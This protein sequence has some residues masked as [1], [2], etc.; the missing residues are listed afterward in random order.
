MVPH[1]N[2]ESHQ[3]S[4]SLTTMSTKGFFKQEL[5]IFSVLSKV[6]KLASP[7]KELTGT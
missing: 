3:W 5:V 4:E 1:N 7:K 6:F 2:T